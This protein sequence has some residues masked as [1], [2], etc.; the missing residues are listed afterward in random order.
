MGKLTKYQVIALSYASVILVGALLLF[1]PISSKTGEVTNFIDCLFTATSAT[2]VT[3]LVI[4]DTYLHWTLFGQIVIIL[5]IQLGGIGFMTIMTLFAGFIKKQLSL[6][7]KNL[8]AFSNG[9]ELSDT[10][11]II[12]KII[13]G[14]F[15]LEGIG[16]IILSTQF[17]PD[18]GVA[19]GIFAS[20]FHAI[21]AF[22]NAG[23]DILGNFGEFSSLAHYLNNYV[24]LITLCLLIFIGGLG[25]LVWDDL[26][27]KK[28]KFSKL[29]LHSKIVLS[30]SF[31]LLFGG[32]ISLFFA[33]Y[34]HTLSGLSIPQK[35]NAS[36]FLSV[37][38]RTC[39]YSLVN[40]AE[41]SECGRFI[42]VLLMRIGGNPGST[43]GG[44]KTTTIV[45]MVFSVVA[46]FRQ[47]NSITLFKKQL[48]P[49][50][51][52][53]SVAIFTTY[54]MAIVVGSIL[55]CAVEPVLMKEAIFEVVSAIGTVGLT[56][57]ITPMLSAF[58]EIVLILLMF[59]GKV[60]MITMIMLFAQKH[61]SVPLE[62][63][64]EKIIV[65]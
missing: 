17:I 15:L 35:I 63:P 65:G 34:N 9:N 43:A 62:R 32:A 19:R 4:Y 64:T 56:M 52:M 18:L 2:C 53:Q 24:V 13:I 16:A 50:V 38:P 30:T 44:A 47:K 48:E 3:G 58:S 5:M 10:R 29:S 33:E 59:G 8:F 14:T 25:F 21:S 42:T 36:L 31:I 27:E 57:G 26:I 60:G 40:Q 28:F 20:I 61:T 51:T 7:D 1:L 55:L 22:C 54:I 6:K 39:G 45:V 46:N 11:K 41:L 37:T 49:T 23:F 12:K